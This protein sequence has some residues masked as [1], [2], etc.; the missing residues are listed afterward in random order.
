MPTPLQTK[1]RAAGPRGADLFGSLHLEEGI[2]SHQ[3][4]QHIRDLVKSGDLRVGDRLPPERELGERLGVSRTVVREAIQILRAEGLVRI[5][6]GV[7][8]FVTQSAPN[9]LEG[10]MSYLQHSEA[11]KIQDLL[12]ARNVIEPAI[13]ALAAE[14]ARPE[15]IAR[16]EQAILDMDG[17]FADGYKYIEHD[18]RF[19]IALAEAS[20]NSVYLLLLNSIVDL[21]QESRLLAVS[22]QGA[23]KRANA[24]H[25]RILEAVR[26]GE[27]K[28]AYAAMVGHMD[29]IA[30]DVRTAMS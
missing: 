15:H 8:T 22:T 4:A 13:A 30:Q 19:H 5:R 6:M 21:L 23:P 7:G 20:N 17:L 1:V 25:R 10:P 12:E 26:A 11:K 9:I 14:N 3:T 16:M 18:N 24:Y 29:Q 2:L 28:K 27:P